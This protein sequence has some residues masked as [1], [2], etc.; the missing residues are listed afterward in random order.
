MYQKD[1]EKNTAAAESH[2]TA[3]TVDV[4]QN[5]A[6]RMTEKYLDLWKK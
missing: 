3:S 5:D 4:Y 1:C 6:P 2:A